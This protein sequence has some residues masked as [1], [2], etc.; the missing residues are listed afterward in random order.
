[1]SRHGRSVTGAG[2]TD[3]KTTQCYIDLAGETFREEAELPE[4]RLF[5]QKSGAEVAAASPQPDNGRAPLRRDFPLQTGATERRRSR[6][7]R[8]VGCTTAPVLK[9][10]WATGPMPLPGR[11]P[12]L[13][14][15]AAHTCT[16]LEV[17][18]SGAPTA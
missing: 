7:Y 11:D 2:H 13:R 8:A 5:G 6:T 18:G 9:T 12:S 15:T 3:F 10:G 17:K 16:A 1:M 4:E 14:Q